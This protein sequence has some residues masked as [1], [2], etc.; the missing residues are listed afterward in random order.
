LE[1]PQRSAS[2]DTTRSQRRRLNISLCSQI[3]PLRFSSSPALFLYLSI[4][5]DSLNYPSHNMPE[6]PRPDGG[7]AAPSDVDVITTGSRRKIPAHSSVLVRLFR[8][9][10]FRFLAHYSANFFCKLSRL[11]LLA[12]LQKSKNLSEVRILLFC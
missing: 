2:S 12:G 8:R 11:D 4:L 9:L 6:A 10:P 7:A 1:G 5:A 3:F